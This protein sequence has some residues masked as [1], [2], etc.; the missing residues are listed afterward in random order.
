MLP[1]H[2]HTHTHTHTEKETNMPHP[3]H[4]MHLHGFDMYVLHE[5]PGAWD[6]SIVRAANPQ[7]RDVI[8]VRGNGHVVIQ[9][10]AATNP[11][12]WPFHCHI[13]WHVSAGLLSQFITNPVEIERMRVPNT[14]AET[15]RQWGAWTNTNIP[16]QIDSGL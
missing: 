14:V 1:A 13:A 2:T 8:Q 9:F 11:G 4:P 16:E 6:N 7:R 10:D 3:R 15:C 12:A 5:G